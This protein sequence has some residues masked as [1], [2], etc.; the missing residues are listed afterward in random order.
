[1]LRVSPSAGLV[2]GE[3][4]K[5]SLSGFPARVTVSV[6]ECA[7]VPSA[8]TVNRCGGATTTLYT[9][10]SGSVSG[11]FIAE[12]AAGTG[13]KGTIVTCRN[14]CVLAGVVIKQ[15]GRASHSPAP[16]AHARL[17]FSTAATPGLADAFLADLSWVS[18]G[19][20]WALATRPCATG[21]AGT[22]AVLAHT[23]DGGAHW[24]ILPTLPRNSTVGCIDISCVG[25][26]AFANSNVGYLYGPGLLMTSDGGRS[27]QAEPGLQVETL[28]IAN[29]AVYRVAYGQS[30]CPGPCQPTLQEAAVGSSVWETLVG[31]LDT[32]D[33]SASAQIVSS[34]TTLL[35]AMYGSQAG[36]FSA[37]AVL[38]RSTDAGGSFEQLSDPCSGMGPVGVEED[39]IDLTSAPGGF[40]AGLC[41]PHTGTGTF[42]VTSN[43]DGSSWQRAGALP[44]AQDQGWGLVAAASSTTLVVAT[45]STSGAGPDTARLLVSTDAGRTWTTAASDAQE[46]TSA[47]IPAWLG[48]ETSQVGRWIGDPHNVWITNDGGQ[49]W[50]RIA[51]G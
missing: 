38:Y 12:P 48:F 40:F 24:Q 15:T 17:S 11:P 39:L 2:G 36:P 10:K 8:A 46:I 4:L 29:G 41:S 19:E 7:G 5:V 49:H 43:D 9:K 47:G 37:Q 50:D 6:Y 35:V 1:M 44:G 28:T 42:V 31:D 32:P 20:G 13:S 23:L 33:R 3:Q 27:W 16:M 14:Q 45:G 26:V 25:S 22:C 51:F 21:S 34:G 18:T 30:A